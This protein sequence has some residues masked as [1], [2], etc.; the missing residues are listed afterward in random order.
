MLDKLSQ[1]EFAH[2]CSFLSV[3]DLLSMSLIN[4]YMRDK[5][6]KNLKKR[7]YDEM[8][9]IVHQIMI[10]GDNEYDDV[11]IY[12]VENS[13]NQLNWFWRGYIY[14]E[15][16]CISFMHKNGMDNNLGLTVPIHLFTCHDD[17][18]TITEDTNLDTNL[19]TNSDLNH[20]KITFTKVCQFL[21]LVIWYLGGDNFSSPL[22]IKFNT[23]TVFIDTNDHDHT[24]I[25][26][27]EKIKAIISQADKIASDSTF[28]I[29][30]NIKRRG[31]SFKVKVKKVWVDIR[32]KEAEAYEYLT[33]R[34][35][36]P[37]LID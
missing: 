37:F 13:Y 30:V 9:E 23:N 25:Y 24:V 34:G 28:R 20:G 7:M 31:T 29:T 22:N 1:D 18:I 5:I 10:Y 8:A 4:K 26:S 16:D 33:S 27:F 14:E 2:L 36:I 21:R 32:D 3:F 11:D 15:N 17:K 19:N 12:A 6:L 35:M